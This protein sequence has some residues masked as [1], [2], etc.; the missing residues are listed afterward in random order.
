[1]PG[2]ALDFLDHVTVDVGQATIDP[3]VS[4]EELRVIDAQ[5]IQDGGVDV[6]DL[7]RITS[8]QR[9]IAPLI[10]WPIGRAAL[11]ATAGQPVR[12]D[13]RIVIAPSAAL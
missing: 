4:H 1:M 8:I 3:I 2:L 10:T 5:Q 9:L 13:E 11:N 6:V 7:G 12:E